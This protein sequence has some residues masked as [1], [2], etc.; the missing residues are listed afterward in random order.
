MELQN[1]MKI[2]PHS[3][4]YNLQTMIADLKLRDHTGHYRSKIE[5]PDNDHEEPVQQRDRKHSEE[6]KK[7]YLPMDLPESVR[8]LLKLSEDA[9]LVCDK[10]T[11][12]ENVL[13]AA[14]LQNI[15]TSV[16]RQL[17]E[18]AIKDLP[19]TLVVG[20]QSTG[21]TTLCVALTG[22]V[23]FFLS[24]KLG[25]KVRTLII[26][27]YDPLLPDGRVQCALTFNDVKQ[28]NLSPDQL[29]QLYVSLFGDDSAIAALNVSKHPKHVSDVESAHIC[30]VVITTS[31][32]SITI[33]VLDHPGYNAQK[34]RGQNARRGV[35]ES[36]ARYMNKNSKGIL[37]IVHR[38]TQDPD[39][40]GW[41]DIANLKTMPKGRVIVAVS[42]LDLL[43]TET[44]AKGIFGHPSF[45]S[46]KT[47]KGG[48]YCIHMTPNQILDYY[49][50]RFLSAE[51][52]KKVVN[53]GL[54]N[55]TEFFFVASCNENLENMVVNTLT[56]DRFPKFLQ[57]QTA[58][59]E[60][61]R[62]KLLDVDEWAKY[63]I[64]LLP[65]TAEET[66]KFESRL[67]V[68]NLLKDL[69][70]KQFPG[71]AERVDQAQR[72][73]DSN[74]DST[75]G[76]LHQARKQLGN[77]RKLAEVIPRFI[78]SFVD[79]FHTLVHSEPYA[80]D[81]SLMKNDKS[82]EAF[83]LSQVREAYNRLKT[84]VGW[85]LQAVDDIFNTFSSDLSYPPTQ[86]RTDDFDDMVT[87]WRP[88]LVRPADQKLHSLK[89]LFD[90]EQSNYSFYSSFI[91]IPPVDIDELMTQVKAQPGVDIGDVMQAVAGHIKESI[92]RIFSK[93]NSGNE[94]AARRTALQ[95]LL[96]S[97]VTWRVLAEVPHFASMVYDNL[98]GV[99]SKD[100]D[101]S[102][103][104]AYRNPVP[105][106]VEKILPYSLHLGNN[107][108]AQFLEQDTSQKGQLVLVDTFIEK[109]MTQLAEY[110]EA[111]K[112][113]IGIPSTDLQYALVAMFFDDPL[114]VMRK[115]QTAESS[116]L[117]LCQPPYL[118]MLLSFASLFIHMDMDFLQEWCETYQREPIA[119]QLLRNLK[120]N[121]AQSQLSDHFKEALSAMKVSG[122]V[123]FLH[124]FSFSLHLFTH[125]IDQE[126]LAPGLAPGLT[127]APNQAV[128]KTVKPHVYRDPYAAP[129]SNISPGLREVATA[130]HSR[131]PAEPLERAQ[132]FSSL[133]QMNSTPDVLINLTIKNEA[134]EFEE[135]SVQYQVKRFLSSGI[136][137][138]ILSLLK[139]QKTMIYPYSHPGMI[140]THTIEL[141]ERV[142]SRL[143][144]YL[145]PYKASERPKGTSSFVH[146]NT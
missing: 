125:S 6:A 117:Q 17:D 13:L 10:K 2:T 81:I 57:S 59:M 69:V 133:T 9:R 103:T 138:S 78:E 60:I 126:I 58:R 25:T 97:E 144:G 76:R 108:D 46:K 77:H 21:K 105:S 68:P 115:K 127:P 92:E 18:K 42:R 51:L 121:Q 104:G 95:V 20:N 52:P 34:E 119:L 73:I 82:D 7:S 87:T 79:L 130:V 33:E 118:P 132:L 64:E 145:Y 53:P 146:S 109:A 122:L 11:S 14:Q 143:C 114:E 3:R 110:R 24:E 98:D 139:N 142:V 28:D 49:Q 1:G 86:Y 16:L 45:A 41:L 124:S 37:L 38:I 29:L 128:P 94:Y 74:L 136:Y 135:N 120:N 66:K 83:Q 70:E 15:V 27:R 72:A 61:A 47:Q 141:M 12:R 100:D 84:S 36:V 90:R 102:G 48:K 131:K 32:P 140:P 26:H 129:F 35:A 96:T 107:Y 116:A 43:D 31:K 101:A 22:Q 30:E 19:Q 63:G 113:E 99:N 88:R 4:Y 67:G 56:Q 23:I 71:I 62:K 112:N 91:E 75:L 44:V 40:G 137:L 8:S 54:P 85:T 106:I 39:E 89:S 65:M 80:Q 123:L 134:N 93:E 5:K 50:A 111:T 55:H